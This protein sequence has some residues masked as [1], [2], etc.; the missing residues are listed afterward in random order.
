MYTITTAKR[1]VVVFVAEEFQ[2]TPKMERKP[3]TIS[4]AHARKKSDIIVEIAPPTMKGRL[5]P[6]FN[7]QLSLLR[8]T[9]GCTRVPERGPAIQ[10]SASRDLL[11]PRDKRY[12]WRE[13]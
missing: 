5:L 1:I 3:A 12:G 13:D 7:R 4:L 10:T 11:R 9:Y 8:P 6:Y 2:A